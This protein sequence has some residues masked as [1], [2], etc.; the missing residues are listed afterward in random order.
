MSKIVSFFLLSVVFL[1]TRIYLVLYFEADISDVS[2]YGKYAL[3]YE[4]SSENGLSFYEFHENR[5]QAVIDHAKKT[6][7][8]P[9][10]ESS[11]IV[12]YPPLAIQWIAFPISFI[13]SEKPYNQR[14]F[15]IY[16]DNYKLL[17]RIFSALLE[18][19]SLG[20]VFH[21]LWN[22]FSKNNVREFAERM[23]IFIL[24]G[25]VLAHVLYERLDIV[26]SV[27]IL[28]SFYLL[29][30]TK[31]RFLSFF[32]LAVAVNFKLVPIVLVPLWVVGSLPLCLFDEKNMA[33]R[34]IRMTIMSLK[35]LLLIT[36]LIVLLVLPYFLADGIDC[37][38]FFAFHMARGI[39]IGS[40]YGSIMMLLDFL[41]GVDSSIYYLH[42]DENLHSSFSPLLLKTSPIL[43][44]VAIVVGLALLVAH[45]LR[46]D[47]KETGNDQETIA[48]RYPEMMAV[49]SLLFL[50]IG[51]SASKV[52]SVQ[53]L[54][55]IIPLV[56]IFPA[57]GGMNRW[58]SWGFLA[59]CTL[60]T[61]VF[62]YHYW[63]LVGLVRHASGAAIYTGPNPFWSS[64][65]ILRNLLFI[66]LTLAVVWKLLKDLKSGA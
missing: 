29:V 52:F 32:V 55:W 6:G 64:F 54:V 28:V 56:V 50:M 19:L 37:M 38:N 35:P 2:L 5:I 48:S 7:T 14:T 16:M 63:D 24:S 20:L 65:L 57:K 18:C 34:L 46:L 53:Y 9:P 47:P 62:P 15:A 8:E 43:L 1:T 25:L 44:S 12:E 17:F 45:T 4:I 11:K 66:A 58:V 13:T 60:T 30:L 39:Q 41:F 33:K 3:E 59:V 22:V 51:I 27:L 26:L 49:Y 42:G 40:V 10:P 36:S 21:L 61:I 31:R 23:S